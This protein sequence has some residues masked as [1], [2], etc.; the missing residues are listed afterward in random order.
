MKMI[1]D[2]DIELMSATWEELL[3]K[4]E[5]ERID[6]MVDDDEKWKTVLDVLILLSLGFAIVFFSL[7]YMYNSV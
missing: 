4:E 5:K 3:G 1:D 2:A 6:K 7:D